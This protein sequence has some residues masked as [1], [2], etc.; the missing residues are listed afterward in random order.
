VISPLGVLHAQITQRAAGGYETI[1][2]QRGNV[3][4]VGATSITV[5]SADG[6]TAT[7]AVTR[8]TVVDAQRSGIG[9]VRTG[10]LVQIR[11]SVTKGKA[12]LTSLTDLSRLSR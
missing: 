10:D 9:S 8:S 1:D 11:A 5:R 7:Y 4:K 3:T 12:T 6:F 2:I